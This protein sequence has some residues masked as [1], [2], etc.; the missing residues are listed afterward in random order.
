[1]GFDSDTCKC[2]ARISGVSAFR[3]ATGPHQLKAQQATPNLRISEHVNRMAATSL[4]PLT[5]H[6]E[7]LRF[8]P[9]KHP[10]HEHVPTRHGQTLAPSSF[11]AHIASPV[12]LGVG[13]IRPGSRVEQD[14]D[15]VEVDER[16][17]ALG[18]VGGEG[19]EV[20]EEGDAV[21]RR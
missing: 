14:R 17:G 20:G 7:R 4:E 13:P 21:E 1:M 12:F 3:P 5:V 8:V 9:R 16:R 18:R 19:G 15:E 11:P 2:S 6:L 10:V